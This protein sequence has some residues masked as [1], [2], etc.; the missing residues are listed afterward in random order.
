M[1]DSLKI[2]CAGKTPK[3]ENYQIP[4]QDSRHPS[5]ARVVGRHMEYLDVLVY[6]TLTQ[7]S[8]VGYQVQA[9]P[10]RVGIHTWSRPTA[11][12]GHSLGPIYNTHSS[13]LKY[14]P[15]D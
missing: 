14:S 13:A 7:D 8:F 5:L 11:A 2:V 3:P 4:G 9:T 15:Q 12:S 1:Y 6:K 10:D